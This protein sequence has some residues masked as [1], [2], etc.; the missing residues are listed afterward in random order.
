[1]TTICPPISTN[2][3]AI[4]RDEFERL[5]ETNSLDEYIRQEPLAAT[6]RLNSDFAVFAHPHQEHGESANNGGPWTTWL[7]LG[8]RGA[9]KTRTGA[10]WVRALVHGIPPY[11]DRPHGCIALVGE[12]EH[13]AREVMVE[14]PSGL[15]AVSA[16]RQRP[17][18]TPT[19]RRLEWPNGAV[20]QVFSA[21][22][23]ESLRT[24]IRRGLVR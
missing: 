22:D 2:S 17:S 6:L 23:P 4:L 18:W 10:E 9:G 7:M 20:A 15:L 5:C 1:M 21:E 24:A 19:R 13:D 14:G 11:A 12:T 3:V 16:R 8:G